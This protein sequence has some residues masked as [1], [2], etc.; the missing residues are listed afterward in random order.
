MNLKKTFLLIGILLV[1]VQLFAQNSYTVS[2]TVV[3][4]TNVPVP[5]VNVV[6]LNTTNGTQTDFDGNYSLL[7]SNGD[8]LQFSYIGFATQTVI[9]NGQST[10]DI[11]LV[12]DTSKLDE[13]VV[14]GK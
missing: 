7:V 6:I 1:N 10:I 2:G 11:T 9:I 13:V 5:G 3:D 12:E 4:E 8:V 14:I